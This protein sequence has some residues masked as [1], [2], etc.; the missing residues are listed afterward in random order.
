MVIQWVRC[1][2]VN[3]YMHMETSLI[4]QASLT[5]LFPL[6]CR[7]TEALRRIQTSSICHTLAGLQLLCSLKLS[8]DKQTR[9]AHPKSVMIII[10]FCLGDVRHQ[11]LELI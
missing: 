6:S 3:T 8:K 2:P 4:D 11:K 10:F 7:D 5:G 1:S 9:H